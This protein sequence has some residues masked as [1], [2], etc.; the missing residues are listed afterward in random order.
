MG[1]EGIIWFLPWLTEA[2]LWSKSVYITVTVS[3]IYHWDKSHGF[4]NE[5]D[6][7]GFDGVFHCL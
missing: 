6:A 2:W 7:S 3:T 5:I 1:L 4:C